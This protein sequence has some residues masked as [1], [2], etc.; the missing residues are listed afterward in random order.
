[1]KKVVEALTNKIIRGISSNEL[2]IIAIIAMI[3]DHLGYY[4]GF[5]FTE[6]VSYLLRNIGR[7]SMPI[8]AF[9]IVEGFFYTKNYK[10]YINRIG[11]AAIMCQI[12]ITTC[13]CINKYFY[14]EYVTNVYK[15]RKYFI[16]LLYI[17]YNFKNNTHRNNNKKVG[18]KQKYYTENNTGLFDINN[19]NIYTARLRNKSSHLNNTLVFL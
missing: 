17:T 16:Y 9:M 8:F 1:M 12:F 15:F 6:K 11:I 2:K 3:S 10:K 18:Y 4:M 19:I 13:Y 7:I 5:I 14:S